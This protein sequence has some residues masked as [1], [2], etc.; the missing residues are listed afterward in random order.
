[1]ISLVTA[2]GREARL[3]AS[4]WQPTEHGETS[5]PRAVL[6]RLLVAVEV[7]SLDQRKLNHIL[8]EGPHPKQICEERNSVVLYF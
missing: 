4:L 1:M 8:E 6:S 5:H 7:R 3:S 2:M